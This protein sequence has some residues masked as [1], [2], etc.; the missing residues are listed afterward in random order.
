M[1]AIYRE[2]HKPPCIGVGCVPKRAMGQML[3]NV[4][5]A[6]S[7]LL[8]WVGQY[9]V[10]PIFGHLNSVVDLTAALTVSLAVCTISVIVVRMKAP[11]LSINDV[12]FGFLVLIV[13]MGAVT[14]P[15][16]YGF[17][18]AL[19]FATVSLLLYIAGR[20]L[21]KDS[22]LSVYL[23]TFLV[24]SIYVLLSSFLWGSWVGFRL[25]SG[26]SANY[27]GVGRVAGSTCIITYV[28]AGRRSHSPRVRALLRVVF[29]IAFLGVLVSGA[30]GPF[31]AF[32][33]TMVVLWL[34]RRQRLS[35]KIVS[36]LGMLL[37]VAAL[38]ASPFATPMI[39]R[40]SVLNRPHEDPSIGTRLWYYS[41][42]FSV[43][44][45]NPLGV[46]TGQFPL[47]VG[48]SG[49]GYPHNIFLE[50]GAENGWVGLTALAVVLSLSL[51][52]S[53]KIIREG[54]ASALGLLFILALTNAMFSGDLNDQRLLWSVCGIIQGW[55]IR[56]TLKK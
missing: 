25:L 24:T 44:A 28:L 38:M 11:K 29:L 30:R 54:T 42:A 53:I 5:A 41:T 1:P 10:D 50:V 21:S 48:T 6:L 46:G 4:Q 51:V 27:L 20:F 43:I 26:A 2:A 36:T 37:I 56:G 12:A 22:A 55:P 8:V 13:L 7:A 9:K 35:V 32:L 47:V 23:I 17:I 14:R 52:A 16:E 31:I 3:L 19:T 15:S 33:C 49:R 45:A 40:L 18:K 39:S 34:V